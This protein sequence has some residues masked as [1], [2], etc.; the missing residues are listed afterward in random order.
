MEDPTVV[1]GFLRDIVLLEAIGINPVIVHGGGKV[2]TAR[3]KE[4]GIETR[5]VAGQRVTSREAVTIVEQS[6]DRVVNSQIVETFQSFGGKAVGLS[7]KN[8]FV[9]S[10]LPLQRNNAGELEDVGFVGEV[11]EIKPA[12]VRCIVESGETPVISPIGASPDGQ[13]Y[14]INAD[15]A[16]AAL[17]EKLQA[18]KLIY[19]SDVEGVLRDAKDPASRL[20]SISMEQIEDLIRTGV[21]SGG[22]IPKLL[23]A[24]RAI[25]AGVQKVHM[26]GGHLPH[27]L[28]LEIF[29]DSGI[30]TEITK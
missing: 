8:V 30:G 27:C 22:M 13:I 1:E 25:R 17:A 3:M 23:S 24:A 2:I 10:K 19:A 4:E 28:L 20:S 11:A 26:I 14:N 12:L 18:T 6:L 7:G 5:F 9:A 15:L 21:V 29:S 16:A